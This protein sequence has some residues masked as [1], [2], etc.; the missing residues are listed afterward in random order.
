MTENLPTIKPQF[1]VNDPE[2]VNAIRTSIAHDATDAEFTMFMMMVKSSGLNPFRKEI[3]FIKTK[4]KR[5]WDKKEGKE[6]VV[7]PKVQMMTGINGY[8]AIANNHPQF[9]GMEETAIEY[10]DKGRFVRAVAKAWRKDR[11][12]P[13][14]GVAY[15]DEYGPKDEGKT[16]WHMK[17]RMMLAKVAESIALRKAFPQELNGLYTEEEMPREYSARAVD[18]VDRASL[19][20][21]R[22]DK[23][24]PCV[25]GEPFNPETGEVITP[26][27]VK[28]PLEI[29]QE[30]IAADNWPELG[31]FEVEIKTRGKGTRK[32]PVAYLVEHNREWVDEQLGPKKGKLPKAYE[33]ALEA[34]SVW[35]DAMGSGGGLDDDQ[36]NIPDTWSS[37]PQG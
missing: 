9:D 31:K 7:P 6:V 21:Y 18:D 12:F 19:D 2:V 16:L 8:F 1:D 32:A 3:W 11:R 25:G 30:L 24:L 33:L 23:G 26:L 37:S 15:W 36:D 35:W 34:F 29:V 27:P 13:S 22:A 5:W 4:E 17:P 14:V 28:Q 10:D 20:A